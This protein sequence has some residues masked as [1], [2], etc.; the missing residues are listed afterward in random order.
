MC[1][2]FMKQIMGVEPTPSAW[3]ADVLP[4]YYICT[5]F[6]TKVIIAHSGTFAKCFFLNFEILYEHF[7]GVHY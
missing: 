3:E 5:L 2:I 1:G 6:L 4:I 7:F